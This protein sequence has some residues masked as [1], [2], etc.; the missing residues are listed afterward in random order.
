[1]LRSFLQR[2]EI[3]GV[4][5][6]VVAFFTF[7]ESHAGPKF[8]GFRFD[9]GS[10]SWRTQSPVNVARLC[11]A[12]DS[13][14]EATASTIA[15]FDGE[16]TNL[17]ADLRDAVLVL[18]DAAPVDPA[19]ARR[20]AEE[21]R[22][23]ASEADREQLRAAWLVERER[24]ASGA[25]TPSG[26]E[27]SILLRWNIEAGYFLRYPGRGRYAYELRE[28]DFDFHGGVWR[29]PSGY[30][31]YRLAAVV[32][33]QLGC[34]PDT[35]NAMPA[36]LEAARELA[37]FPLSEAPVAYG[38][39]RLVV[40]STEAAEDTK[41][42]GKTMAHLAGATAEMVAAAYDACRILAADD[43]DKARRRNDVGFGKAHVKIGHRLAT[44]EIEHRTAHDDAFA[45]KLSRLHRKQLPE[46]LAAAI[47]KAAA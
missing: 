14:V 38:L 17:P 7:A 20:I 29:S 13:I 42:D 43:P 26:A 16:R 21:A 31:A 15:A 24:Q 44:M 18:V 47:G 34:L 27:A 3:E 28:S 32:A 8:A 23:A 33:R 11:K 6:W 1:M 45:L 19:Q 40:V 30:D 37:R 36:T 41:I 12:Q 46:D 22:R 39:P 5:T 9:G 4:A 10:K 25:E 35:D 2:N